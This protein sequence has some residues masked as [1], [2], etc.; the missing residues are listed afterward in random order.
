MVGR[1][2][3]AYRRW[4]MSSPDQ[5]QFHHDNFRQLRQF[6]RRATSKAKSLWFANNRHNPI[7]QNINRISNRDVRV[8]APINIDINTLNKHFVEMGQYGT[9]HDEM[10]PPSA[11]SYTTNSPHLYTFEPVIPSAV[12]I[13]LHKMSGGKKTS[14]PWGI[15]HR[16]LRF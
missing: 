13:L 8:A 1:R 5:Q 15:P 7:W 11:R 10:S 3:A 6:L 12:F 16:L 4:K 14:G 9:T 2:D